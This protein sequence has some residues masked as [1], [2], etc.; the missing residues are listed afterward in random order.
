M[1]LSILWPGSGGDAM[2]AE[3]AVFRS[4]SDPAVETPGLPHT[5]GHS[6]LSAP[7]QRSAG[8]QR[9]T[10]GLHPLSNL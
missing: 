9:T 8:D 2:E 3:V 6:A 7:A 10:L 5:V 1:H 4:P